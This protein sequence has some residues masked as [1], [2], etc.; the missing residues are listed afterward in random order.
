MHYN[1]FLN[2][3]LKRKYSKIA[4]AAKPAN[5]PIQIPTAFKE[6]NSPK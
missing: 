3:Y 4:A 1:L 2:K 5:K 6:M